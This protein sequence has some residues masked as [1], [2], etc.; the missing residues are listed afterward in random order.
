MRTTAGRTS[1]HSYRLQLRRQQQQEEVVMQLWMLWWQQ[2]VTHPGPAPSH[3]VALACWRM[4]P[5]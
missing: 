3:V 2:P 1:R 5:G 4:T